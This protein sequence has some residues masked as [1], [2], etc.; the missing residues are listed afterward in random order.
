M[1]AE[2]LGELDEAR[3]VEFA[4]EVA[5]FRDGPLDRDRVVRV[6]AQIAGA[7]LG[8]GKSGRLPER[9]STRSQA[10]VAPSRGSPKTRR[11][12]EEGR[13][14]NRPPPA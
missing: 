6:G 9:S 2:I 12:R 7:Q 13:R 14:R 5:G 4:D 8:R 1:G 11:R 10:E 3:L